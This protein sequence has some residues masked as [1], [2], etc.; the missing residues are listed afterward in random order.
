M[1]FAAKTAAYILAL[2]TAL[3]CLAG[4]MRL[5]DGADDPKKPGGVPYATAE[6]VPTSSSYK[7]ALV[8]ISKSMELNGC[9]VTYP[10]VCDQNSEML[11]VAI[12]AAFAEFADYCDSP[13]SSITYTTEFNRYGLLSFLM[14]CSRRIP[15]I[16]TAARYAAYTSPPASA[17]TGSLKRGSGR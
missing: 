5:D 8:I 7:F 9:S 13:G 11:N 15:P 12:H 14:I 3:L 6:P 10:F 2:L 16:S 1:S 17:P 4:C